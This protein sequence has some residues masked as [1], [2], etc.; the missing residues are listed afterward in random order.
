MPGLAG[1]MAPGQYR[2]PFEFA[3]PA[4][5][6]GTFAYQYG[7]VEGKVVRSPRAAVSCRAGQLPRQGQVP[8]AQQREAGPARPADHPRVRAI[9]GVAAAR[10]GPRAAAPPIHPTAPQAYQATQEIEGCFRKR[11]AAF[12][13]A[14]FNKVMS[15]TAMMC[16]DA[17]QSSYVPGEL[18]KMHLHVSNTSQEPISELQV[19]L[20]RTIVLR[21]LAGATHTAELEVSNTHV[22]LP[23]PPGANI[24]TTLYLP[25]PTGL[26]P[27]CNLRLLACFY[28]VVTTARTTSS[29]ASDAALENPILCAYGIAAASHA[30]P[31]CCPC[32]RHTPLTGWTRRLRR[33]GARRMC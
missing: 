15:R 8:R 20:R 4:A 10:P 31:G 24:E 25:V 18:V 21:V 28:A 16:A 22:E 13:E 14:H 9:P 19:R 2:F 11:G 17:P 30:S 5:T 26:Q 3:L 33:P 6:P 29:C 12:L 1:N 27:S 32:C 7:A 23:I